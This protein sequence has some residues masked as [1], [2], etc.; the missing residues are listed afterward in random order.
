M[1]QP[2]PRPAATPCPPRHDRA[3]RR[4]HEGPH[5]GAPLSARRGPAPRP[6]LRHPARAPRGIHPCPPGRF[7]PGTLARAAAPQSPLRPAVRPHPARTYRPGPVVEPTLALHLAAQVPPVPHHPRRRATHPTR[8]SPLGPQTG[9][10]LGTAPPPPTRT[11]DRHR[12]APRPYST[13]SGIDVSTGVLG[14]S[15]VRTA[16]DR[17]GGRR[18]QGARRTQQP[19]LRCSGRLGSAAAMHDLPVRE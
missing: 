4:N 7:S 12:P 6:P 2:Q 19:A 14:G 16:T 3:C 13:R 10:A 15:L 8:T 18:G 5:N 11:P 1:G 9:H 17:P